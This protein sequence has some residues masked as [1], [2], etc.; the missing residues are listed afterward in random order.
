MTLTAPATAPPPGSLFDGVDAPARPPA[1]DSAE[2]RFTAAGDD[3]YASVAWGRRDAR[4]GAGDDVAFEQAGVEFPTSWSD[5]AVNITASKYFRGTLGTPERESS[6]RELLDRVVDTIAAWGDADGYFRTDAETQVFADEL[7]WLLLHQRAAFNS[8]VWFNIGVAGVPQ[9]ASACFILAVEDTMESILNWY[10]EE[11]RI[12]KG[13][14]GAGVNLSAIRA[15]HE[16]LAGGGRGSG[17]VSFMRGADASAGSIRSGGKTRRAAKMVLLD[18]DHPDIE[19]FIWCKAREERKARALADAG[20][21]MGVNG[22]DGASLQ[23]QNGNNS[24]RLSDEF[25]AAV[26]ADADWELVARTDGSVAKT[27]RARELLR[28]IAEAAWECADPGVQFSTTINA[29]HTAPNAGPITASNPC[30]E[31]VHLDNSACNLASINLL[32][33]LDP[34]DG[35]DV[36]GF[37]HTCRVM[38]VAQDILVGRADYPTE[39]I[40]DTTRR[41][42]QLG[43]GYSNLG[44]ALMAQGLPYDSGA[45]R[46]WAAS[47]TS[48]MTA[49]A[50]AASAELA[51]RVGP[52]AGYTADRHATTLVL[53][54]HHRHATDQWEPWTDINEAALRLW[55]RAVAACEHGPGVRNAQATVIAPTGTI[56][57]MM[58]CDTTG[59]EPDLGLIKHKTLAGGGHL[60][61]VNRTVAR[62]LRTLGHSDAEITGIEAHIEAHGDVTAAP[63]LA[64]DHQAVFACAM[65]R[66]AISAAGHV[67]MMGAVQPFV[68]GAIS[69]TVNLPDTAT[70]DDI[71]ALW[72]SAH[73]LGV[74]AV[75]VYRDNS[76]VGQP[77]ETASSNGHHHAEATPEGAPAARR[78]LPQRRAS[79]TIRFQV[80]DCK[81]FMTVG[82]YPD[83]T[84]GEIFLRVAKGGSTLAGIMDAFAIA[85]SQG[86]QH[87]VPLEAYVDSFAGVRFEPAG[88][89]DDPEL[90]MTTSLVDYL[91]RRLAVEYLPAGIRAAMGV[92]TTQERSEPSLPG[93]DTFQPAPADPAGYGNS[94]APLCSTCGQRMG[95]A[96]TC[97]ACSGCGATSG[98]S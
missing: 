68:S 46:L 28:Q 83:G 33:Y 38:I 64:D 41:Y 66:G 6:L 96:G 16:S 93:L 31:Y 84:P 17:P 1:A 25:M 42:R 62:A 27:V 75:A 63:H 80:G 67:A 78:P 15:S 71:E 98:C 60:T 50:Y 30:S 90:R 44:A 70:P 77:L 85:V 8:P 55:A 45:G 37:V 89:T 5:T 20:F 69:K 91:A 59:I 54:R 43:L 23:Y 40:G 18:V 56:S 3:V 79:R 13:G 22:A 58:D 76:K 92:L 32:A 34:A 7:R 97:W 81:G 12:F 35:F 87:G 52:F 26:E 11:G 86:L 29:W 51:Q 48:L 94:T 2:R 53:R 74:K 73:S 4:I 9:Q 19:E 65:G 47:V 61:I 24:V 39:A 36:E 14:S 49:A 88:L 82:E 57:F 72:R 10:T 95:R 21:A